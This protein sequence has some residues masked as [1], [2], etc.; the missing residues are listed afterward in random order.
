MQRGFFQPCRT[1]PRGIEAWWKPSYDW[2][3]TLFICRYWMPHAHFTI[4]CQ[5]VILV[6]L[7]RWWCRE[8]DSHVYPFSHKVALCAVIMGN[9]TSSQVRLL[10]HRVGACNKLEI[11]LDTITVVRS[12]R[13]RS[14]IKRVAATIFDESSF[15]TPC[16]NRRRLYVSFIDHSGPWRRKQN[17]KITKHLSKWSFP[18]TPIGPRRSEPA[19]VHNRPPLLPS[20][21]DKCD[22]SGF[23]LQLW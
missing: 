23:V 16:Q 15:Y 18:V 2:L 3:R 13:I 11:I 17:L 8:I 20:S 5:H 6:S 14:P 21:H 19:E 12:S 9:S 4:I 7:C 10:Y 1:H 22:K